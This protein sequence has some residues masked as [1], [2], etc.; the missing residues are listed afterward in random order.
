MTDPEEET[1]STDLRRALLQLILDQ[2]EIKSEAIYA[3]PTMQDE[4]A[5]RISNFLWLLKQAGQAVADE[6]RHYTITAK[7]RDYLQGRTAKP[8]AK[9]PAAGQK[10]KSRK[11]NRRDVPPSQ[12]VP[13]PAATG[14]R[15]ILQKLLDDTQAALDEYVYTL[16]D[17]RILDR[18]MAARNSARE[19]LA[20]HDQPAGGDHG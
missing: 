6:G 19:A 7:G 8:A 4:E 14:A 10:A 18:L 11:V 12:L 20:A 9:T 2:P 5:K 1:M 3:H 16:G 13:V 15:P 17:K